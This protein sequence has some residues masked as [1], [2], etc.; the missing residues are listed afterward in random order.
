MMRTVSPAAILLLAAVLAAC[1]GTPA[2]EVT[3]TFNE[4]VVQE[5]IT[6]TIEVLVS[7]DADADVAIQE[8]FPPVARASLETDVP[9]FCRVVTAEIEPASYVRDVGC[10]ER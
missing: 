6:E 10:D 4:T 9:D 2:Y 1:G 5:D 3:V 7:Y 8:S